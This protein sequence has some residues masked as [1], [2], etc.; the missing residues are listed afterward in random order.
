MPNLYAFPYVVVLKL[1]WFPHDHLHVN[2]K[3]SIRGV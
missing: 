3:V 2:L 1:I